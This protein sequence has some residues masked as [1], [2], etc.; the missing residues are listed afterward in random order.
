M[1][2]TT[3]QTQWPTFASNISQIVCE[4][5]LSFKLMVVVL[6]IALAATATVVPLPHDLSATFH[7]YCTPLLGHISICKN[8]FRNSELHQLKTQQKQQ[9]F[10]R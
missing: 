2:P 3:A 5:N 10:C 4:A 8:S 9:S 1:P 7:V 6:V